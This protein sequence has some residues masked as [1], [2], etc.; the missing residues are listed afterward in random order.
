MCSFGKRDLTVQ[1]READSELL[2]FGGRGRRGSRP[3]ETAGLALWGGG[4]GALRWVTSV[5]HL[6][7]VLRG[8]KASLRHRQSR[9]IPVRV[10]KPR[11]L[12]VFLRAE[13]V[14]CREVPGGRA[15]A[16]VRK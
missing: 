15:M 14:Y 8:A 9:G 4:G 2:R 13:K 16:T 6:A 10:A 3:G 5:R 7:T 1:G 12:F 11:R